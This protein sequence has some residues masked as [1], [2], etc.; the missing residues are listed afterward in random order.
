MKPLIFTVAITIVI[1]CWF[2]VELAEWSDWEARMEPARN[3]PDAEAQGD[4]GGVMTCPPILGRWVDREFVVTAYCPKKCCCGKFADGT[5]ASGMSVYGPV[6]RFLAA[7]EQIP[8][9]TVFIVPGYN[10]DAPTV[11]LDR[12]PGE[13]RKLDCYFADHQMALEFGRRE[14]TVKLWQHGE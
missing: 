13:G 1:L 11:V 10:S 12:M 6:R 5:T 14:L 9:G 3:V 8:F 4:A 2:G 7:P